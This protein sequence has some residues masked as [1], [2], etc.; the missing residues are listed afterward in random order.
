VQEGVEWMIDDLGLGGVTVLPAEAW[1]DAGQDSA[2][3]ISADVPRQMRAGQRYRVTL[4]VRNTGR[5]PWRRDH[6]VRLGSR[7]PDN[8]LAWGLGRVE[9]PG[10]VAPGETVPF[11][12]EVVAPALPG[13]YAFSWSMV[14]EGVVWVAPIFKIGSV[15]VTKDDAPPGSDPQPH[16]SQARPH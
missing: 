14:R 6:L 12:F 7:E 9:L 11:S 13:E 5:R 16:R 3:L 2:A 1:A 10:D 4:V 8:N 15:Q